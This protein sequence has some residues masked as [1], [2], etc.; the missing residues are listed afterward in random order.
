M[1]IEISG[2]GVWFLKYLNSDPQSTIRIRSS[3]LLKSNFFCSQVYFYH[4][5]SKIFPSK[6]DTYFK[7]LYPACGSGFFKKWD[8]D[9]N[10]DL[11]NVG[12]GLWFFIILI[13]NTVFKLE[14]PNYIK[15][16]KTKIACMKI[17]LK[18]KKK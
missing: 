2:F 16:G 8:P 5:F 18:A 13:R 15:F 10:C 6:V 9:P 7:I 4:Y 3:T 11:I 1:I 17:V 14:K 12:S